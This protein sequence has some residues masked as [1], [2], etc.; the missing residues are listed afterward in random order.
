MALDRP[1]GAGSASRLGNYELL[2]ELSG[3]GIGATWLARRSSEEESANAEPVTI[4]R[5]YR[6][7]T[8]KAEIVANVLR[9]AENAQKVRSH[10]VLATLEARIAD[11]EV[12]VVSEY[13]E[14]EQL[15]ALITAAG[16]EGLPAPVVLRVALDV[17]R[18]LVSAHAATPEPLV[19]GELNPSH[20]RVG[21]DGVTRVGGFGVAR[22]LAG[23][24]PM[25][26]RSHDR[27]A[28]AAPERVKSMAAHTEAPLAPRADLFSA[29]VLLW[30]G[31]A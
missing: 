30:E 7:L 20:I 27:L 16:T 9:E 22:A 3:G 31:L 18:A 13:A 11:G 24:A 23:I 19:H 1:P 12:F 5:I 26:S 25:G 6:H 28:Y 4:L 2:K 14:G 10:N 29:G 17:L 15:G 8:K 21:I